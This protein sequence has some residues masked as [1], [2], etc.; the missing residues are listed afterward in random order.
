MSADNAS[1]PDSGAKPAEISKGRAWAV[2]T[3]VVIL[4]LINFGD[5]AVV[6]LAAEP[7]MKDLNL[8]NTEFGAIASSFY[9]LFGLSAIVVGFISVRVPTT[10]VLLVI[11]LLWSV[12]MAPVLIWATIPVLYLSRITLGFA[13]GPTSPIGVHAVHKWFPEDARALP[14]SLTQVGGALGVFIAG[15]VLTAIIYRFSWEVAFGVLAA[16]SAVWALVWLFVGKEGPLSTYSAAWAGSADEAASEP[17]IKYRHLMISRTWLG[18]LITGIGAYWALAVGV[19]WLPKLLDMGFDYS[20]STI[21]VLIAIPPALSAVTMLLV[22]WISD[23]MMAKG[24]SRRVAY[25]VVAGS[26]LVIC[27]AAGVLVPLLHGNAALILIFIMVGA[28]SFVYPM[29]YLMVAHT[30][31]VKPRGAVMGTLVGLITSTGL[32]A[33]VI[34]GGVM[35][36]AA[37]PYLGFNNVFLYSGIIMIITGIIGAITIHPESDAQRF[38]LDKYRTGGG[39]NAMAT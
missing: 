15:P 2:V 23:R 11:A 38:G 21:G 8:S 19:A 22:P 29:S 34:A 10:K 35:D 36:A 24:K 9:L 27:G 4:M 17:T 16:T 1:H 7:I 3:M 20:R 30:S 18:C 39:K 6:G 31:P 12:A 14:T 13:E 28:P 25:G 5:K 32:I 26:G 33:P 37:T